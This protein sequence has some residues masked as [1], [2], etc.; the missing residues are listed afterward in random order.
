MM[1]DPD[2]A[3]SLTALTDLM[4][5]KLGG[6]P[7]AQ[8]RNPIRLADRGESP[9]FWATNVIQGHAS[10]ASLQKMS[11]RA[12]VVVIIG[13]KI[14]RN[15]QTP[16]GLTLNPTV[17]TSPEAWEDVNRNSQMDEPGET[18][19]T[20]DL[21]YAIEGKFNIAN[22]RADMP[23]EQ[24]QP[25]DAARIVVIG[26]ADT[27]AN[28]IISGSEGNALFYIDALHWL[29]GDDQIVGA[30]ASEKDVPIVHRKDKDNIWFYGTSFI[31]PAAV[32]GLGLGLSKRARRTK[33][34]IKE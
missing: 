26:D 16:P 31:I 5:I 18:K 1:M 10:V 11:G 4:G 19:Q 33:R 17:R 13:Q 21:A 3:S 32:L 34:E 30:P 8:K 2:S 22:A 12:G 20:F 15:P 23:K 14:E 28:G 25:G 9:Y 7:V 29:G 24:Q 6:L 27:A